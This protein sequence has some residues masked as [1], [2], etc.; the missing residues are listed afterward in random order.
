MQ[1]SILF[2][3]RN[4]K[5]YKSIVLSIVMF[6]L[7]INIIF[8]FVSSITSN[9]KSDVVDN[10]KL[11]FMEV[12]TD[13]DISILRDSL[14]NEIKEISGVAAVLS[15]Y[16]NVMTLYGENQAEGTST[17]FIGVPKE[18]LKYFNVDNISDDEQFLY[19][20][21]SVR[22]AENFKDIETIYIEA[23]RYIFEDNNLTTEPYT[24]ERK[25]SG[26]ANIVDTQILPPDISLIDE[27]GAKEIAFASTPPGEEPMITKIIVIVPDVAEMRSVSDK[28]QSLNPDIYTKYD[29]KSTNELP[30]FAVLI[31]TISIVLFI[32]LF[33]I[34][35][36]NIRSNIKQL[37]ITRIRDIA[38]FD[39]FGIKTSSITFVFL[40]EF[41]FSGTI[42][43]IFAILLT[44]LVLGII[45]FGFGL[46]LITSYILHYALIDIVLTLVMVIITGYIEIKLVE[47]KLRKNQFYKEVIR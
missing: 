11:Y 21:D 12:K 18:S 6:L 30:R 3:K 15:E 9:F 20:N 36:F 17:T 43:F 24:I 5:K 42:A 33:I 7:L 4:Y 26:M 45:N 19:L 37:L 27:E 34:S 35:F 10:S 47:R 22:N 32:I 13:K 38:L 29:L 8:G 16:P 41:I 46:D 39:I 1:T 23:I 31:V 28:I 14:V 25:L 2:F 44:I 40:M